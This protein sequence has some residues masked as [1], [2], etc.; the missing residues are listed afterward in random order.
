VA[1]GKTFAS[2]EYNESMNCQAKDEL[3]SQLVALNNKLSLLGPDLVHG[4]EERAEVQ[5]L[6]ENVDTEI[7]H[8]RAKGHEGKPCPAAKQAWPVGDVTTRAAIQRKPMH[9]A[10]KA[11]RPAKKPS[12]AIGEGPLFQMSKCSKKG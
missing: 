8:H 12:K 4:E 9:P 5:P 11:S 1:F 10:M 6:S 2:P 7:K 3:V